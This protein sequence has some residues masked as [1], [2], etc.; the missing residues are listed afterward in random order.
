MDEFGFRSPME[1]DPAVPRFREQ[2]IRFFEQLRAVAENTD[3]EQNPQAILDRAKAQREQAYEG[4]LRVARRKGRRQAKQ[5]AKNYNI[6]I[7]LGGYRESSKYFVALITDQFRK[8]VLLAA[9]PLVDARR[10]D[11]LQQAFD[12]TMNDLAQGIADPAIDLRSLAEKN[13]RFPKRLQQVGDLPRFI[14]SRGKI[15]RAPSKEAGEGDLAGEPISPGIVRGKVKV[16]HRPDEKPILPG[17]ILVARATDPGWTPLFL[18]AG[19]VVL[20][21]GGMLQHGALVAREYGKPCVAGIEGA[22]LALNDGQMIQVDGANGTIT[23]LG[24]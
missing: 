23:V 19:G 2:P 9:Q 4:L 21:V 17:E 10:L 3:P 16:L 5:F 6:V 12:L 18:N 20:E 22:T 24:A 13:T 8:S 1:M 14:D 15:L 7:E 11:T